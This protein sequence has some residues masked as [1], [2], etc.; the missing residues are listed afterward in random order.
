M[1][2]YI[3]E[4]K[5]RFSVDQTPGVSRFAALHR[6]VYAAMTNARLRFT[7]EQVIELLQCV[8]PL[9]FAEDW[10]QYAGEILAHYRVS[11]SRPVSAIEVDTAA[12]DPLLSAKTALACAYALRGTRVCIVVPTGATASSFRLWV[13]AV[14][15]MSSVPMDVHDAAFVL[16]NGSTIAV[17][18][19]LEDDCD[20]VVIADA[21]ST[22]GDVARRLQLLTKKPNRACFM[23][24][25]TPPCSRIGFDARASTRIASPPVVTPEPVA[26]TPPPLFAP[27]TPVTITDPPSHRALF[28]DEALASCLA[29]IKQH[30]ARRCVPAARPLPPP[31]PFMSPVAIRG[32]ARAV[33]SAWSQ[34][35]PVIGK[36]G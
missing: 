23:Y 22:P 16:A 15:D 17:G 12:I 21:N 32:A 19:D 33:P 18:H 7:S 9:A 36:H 13:R 10:A 26:A 24:M 28:S 30:A 25:H 6:M 34:G 29:Q 35:R 1:A 11:A 4:C 14:A 27:W 5:S 8:L 3:L 20:L 31:V 2:D